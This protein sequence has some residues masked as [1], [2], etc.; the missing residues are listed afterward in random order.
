MSRRFLVPLLVCTLAACDR[1]SEPVAVPHNTSHGMAQSVNSSEVNQ[2]LAGLRAAL[3]PFH[4]FEAATAAGYNAQITPCMELA[5]AGGMGFHYGDTR[6]I[7]AKVEE[8][9][10]ELL[11]Y[12][13]QK[14][15]RLR[16]VA[17]EYIVPFDA[18]TQPEPPSLHGLT[19]HANNTFKVW[20]LHAWVW[21]HNP[22]GLFTDWNPRISCAAN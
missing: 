6:L 17:V 18:W 22:A 13:P 14:N 3:A 10:P 8:F 19:F 11:L 9:A 16:L 5:G 20:A 1:Q 2:W 21:Q 4:R 7:D 12:E 15:G